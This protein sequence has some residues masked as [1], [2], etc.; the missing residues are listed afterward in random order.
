MRL[1]SEISREYSVGARPIFKYV[2]A[3]DDNGTKEEQKSLNSTALFEFVNSD[4]QTFNYTSKFIETSFQH[5]GF[6]LPA[7][8][9][10]AEGNYT[11]TLG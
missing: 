6:V 10:D 5:Y 7:I 4:G 3:T 8:E 2:I 11:L 9:E 1:L